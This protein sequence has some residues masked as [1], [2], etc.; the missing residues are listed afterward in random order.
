M[1]SCC[2]AAGC[3]SGTRLASTLGS[4][5]GRTLSSIA[6]AADLGHRF[7]ALGGAHPLI[8]PPRARSAIAAKAV[9]TFMVVVLFT[10]S[11]PEIAVFFAAGKPVP[12]RFTPPQAR[13]RPAPADGQ[14]EENRSNM[15]NVSACRVRFGG[16]SRLA[17]AV[18]RLEARAIGR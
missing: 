4:K 10:L 2:S 9:R 3:S 16:S 8:E 1:A 6:A 17:R 7:R 5:R 15:V 18:G 11:A 14:R 12:R 13:L